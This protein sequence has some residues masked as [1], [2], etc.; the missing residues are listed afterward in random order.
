MIPEEGANGGVYIYANYETRYLTAALSENNSYPAANDAVI[1]SDMV[2]SSNSSSVEKAEFVFTP[3][4]NGKYMI[5]L[6]SNPRLVLTRTA[7]G[8]KLYNISSINTEQSWIITNIG[9]EIKTDGTG[10]KSGI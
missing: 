6:L 10:L 5:Q 1:G 4:A 9:D 2:T 7:N 3:L 8:L